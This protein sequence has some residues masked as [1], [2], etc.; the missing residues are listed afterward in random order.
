MSK[1]KSRFT[2]PDLLD[3]SEVCTD[4]STVE[5]NLQ[6]IYDLQ[7]IIIHKG[8]F[9]SGHY[10]SYVRPNIRTDEWYR[11]NDEIVTH[12]SYEEVIADAFGGSS[13]CPNNSNRG[14]TKRRKRR[15]LFG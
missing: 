12:V 2:F 1:I 15:G 8:E 13:S 5:D 4:V 7:S 10:Y 14:P 9:G 3:L 6:S 11:I